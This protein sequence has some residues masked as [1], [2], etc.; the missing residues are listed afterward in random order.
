[1]PGYVDI[2]IIWTSIQKRDKIDSGTDLKLI[3]FGD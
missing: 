1:L 2:G 3:E